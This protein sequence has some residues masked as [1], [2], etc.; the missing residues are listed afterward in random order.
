[1]L[2][3]FPKMGNRVFDLR[4]RLYWSVLERDCQVRWT[5]PP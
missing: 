5:K 4:D 1:M 3:T 2:D